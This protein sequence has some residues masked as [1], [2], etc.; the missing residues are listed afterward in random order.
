MTTSIDN[1]WPITGRTRIIL[2]IAWVLVVL[3]YMSGYAVAFSENLAFAQGGVVG[4]MVEKLS[5]KST[6]IQAVV[7]GA[8][9]DRVGIKVGDKLLQVD[10]LIIQPET[11]VNDIV[12]RIAGEAGKEV[13]LVVS[14]ADNQARTMDI[15]RGKSLPNMVYTWSLL[16]QTIFFL[17]SGL[18]IFL[19]RS[20]SGYALFVALGLIIFGFN[21]AGVVIYSA[22]V[23]LLLFAAL[24]LMLILFILLTYPNGTFYPSWSYGIG[25]AG[26]V[27]YGLTLFPGA[28]DPYEWPLGVFLLAQ[29]VL[30]AAGLACQALRYRR[31]ATPDERQQLH[32]ALW[33]AA[34]AMIVFFLFNSIYNIST[35][36]NWLYL[37]PSVQI[38]LYLVSVCGFLAVPVTLVISMLRIEPE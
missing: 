3:I 15:T 9:A 19:K 23:G 18:I 7:P 2:C 37:N 30:F 34:S 5:D 22:G 36:Y 16:A 11:S 26:V 35:L 28:L 29:A 17:L 20:Q 6:A 25:I 24:G 38:L 1:P 12:N 27:L 33:G 31:M 21:V 10:D 4:I 14:G 32:L 13:S 8:P